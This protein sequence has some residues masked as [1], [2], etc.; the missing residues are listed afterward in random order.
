MD[1][2]AAFGTLLTD[3]ADYFDRA[4]RGAAL[5]TPQQFRVPSGTLFSSFLRSFRV[6][7]A[8]TVDKGGPLA[9]SPEMAMVLI[10]I[11][12]A[13]QYPVLM[14]TLFPRVLAT[15][16]RPYDSIVTL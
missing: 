6:G 1:G 3:V 7:V 15:L 4:P 13:Q 16:E 10:R 11:R 5:A 2:P 12:T 14:P 8:S 9:L